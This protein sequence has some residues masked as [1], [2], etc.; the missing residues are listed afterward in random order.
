MPQ[1]IL[2]RHCDQLT[3]TKLDV[4]AILWVSSRSLSPLDL[5]PSSLHGANR[6]QY[7]IGA[8][9]ED[10]GTRDAEEDWLASRGD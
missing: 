9:L 3:V 4:P 5:D 8:L 10:R 7:S 6:E 1:V 2:E